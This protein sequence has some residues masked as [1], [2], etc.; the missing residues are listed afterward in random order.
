MLSFVLVAR[1]SEVAAL[2][3]DQLSDY[4]DHLVAF[5]ERRKC[6]QYME[7]SF[8]PFVDSGVPGGAAA[9]LLRLYLTYFKCDDL[10][11]PLI[12]G[13]NR[14][15]VR[16]QYLRSTCISYSQM[17]ELTRGCLQVVS[18]NHDE[19]GLHSYRAGA[20][21]YTVAYDTVLDR[22]WAKQGGW[23]SDC[24]DGY[25]EEDKRTSL[26]AAHSLRL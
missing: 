19:Y 23:A 20:G 8:V 26:L 16:G 24:K 12:M 5:L 22:L 13:V 10:F 9:A 11:G 25:V 1:W 15:K 4:G 17:R 7:D 14:G 6:D 18:E 21:T 2:R 3:A